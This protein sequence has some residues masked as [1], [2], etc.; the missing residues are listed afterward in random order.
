M[1]MK[2]LDNPTPDLNRMVSFVQKHRTMGDMADP[3][4]HAVAVPRQ[5]TN[6]IQTNISD[7]Q[8]GLRTVIA[9]LDALAAKQQDIKEK[10]TKLKFNEALDQ[11]TWQ[12]NNVPRTIS[13]VVRQPKMFQVWLGI[14][15]EIVVLATRG[16]L[17]KRE[18]RPPFCKYFDFP[19]FS[20]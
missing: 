10:P 1:R 16:Q 9:Q 20:Q 13:A 7:D 8:G 4:G 5:W 15:Q 6:V 12:S 11:R 19:N 18:G 14:L 17:N 3:F 2:L